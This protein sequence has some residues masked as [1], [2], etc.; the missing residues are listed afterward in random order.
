VFV[1]E[2]HVSSLSKKTIVWA[3]FTKFRTFVNKH[4]L[5][6]ALELQKA[7]NNRQSFFLYPTKYFDPL[8]NT[9]TKELT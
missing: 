9:M 8:A 7:F 3:K 4:S 5:S 2:G 6:F 1:K